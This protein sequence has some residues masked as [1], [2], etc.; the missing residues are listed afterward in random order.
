MPLAAYRPAPMAKEGLSAQDYLDLLPPLD[1]AHLQRDL[2]TM[3]GG[4][5]HT[6]LGQ[7]DK[8]AFEDPRVATPLAAFQKRLVEVEQIIQER[9]ATRPAYGFLLPSLIPQSINI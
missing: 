5:R 3:L 4:L 8:G 6:R 2:G 1:M 9:N 7:Y